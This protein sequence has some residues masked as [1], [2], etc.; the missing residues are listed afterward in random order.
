MMLKLANLTFV[1][2]RVFQMLRKI[3][4]IK[5]CQNQTGPTAATAYAVAAVRISR[6]NKV[7]APKILK[8]TFEQSKPEGDGAILKYLQLPHFYLTLMR[9]LHIRPKDSQYLSKVTPIHH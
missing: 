9:H 6:H 7:T 5:R 8:K 1:L 4:R 2:S 3:L